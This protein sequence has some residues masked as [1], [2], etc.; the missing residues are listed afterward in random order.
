MNAVT[1]ISGNIYANKSA[2]LRALQH[3]IT[4]V[5]MHVAHPLADGPFSYKQATWQRYETEVEFYRTIAESAFYIAYCDDEIDGQTALQIM[6][7]MLR[8]RPVIITGKLRYARSLSLFARQTLARHA[9]EFHRVS[10]DDLELAELSLLLRT[11]RPKSYGL[12]DTE[13]L[14]MKS[15]LRAHFRRIAASSP[16]P[17]APAS[18]AR[19]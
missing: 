17:S 3:L 4:F 5:G 18:P 15:L 9:G 2:P 1:H 13:K 8:R 7:A 19:Q 10:L 16:I 14:L 12:T 6:Y 11:R